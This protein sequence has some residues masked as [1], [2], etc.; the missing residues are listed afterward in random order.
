MNILYFSDL[1]LEFGKLKYKKENFEKIDL[2]IAAGDIGVGLGGVHGLTKMI[3][4]TIPVLYVSGNHEYYN[5]EITLTDERL[6]EFCQKTPNI[7]FLQNSS[8]EFINKDKIYKFIGGT[9]W[10]DFNLNG[11]HNSWFA[12]QKAKNVMND[13][14]CIRY[15]NNLL[16]PGLTKNLHEETLRFILLELQ[17]TEKY[18]KIFII[19]HHTPSIQS[20]YIRNELTPAYGSNLEYLMRDYKIDYW[21]HGHV[22][23]TNDYKIYNTQI[24]S[25]PR[26]Y[27]N[28]ETN[29]EFDPYKVITLN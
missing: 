23:N 2:I 9:L 4:S 28:Y 1:H 18:D 5:K 11:E 17:N 14:R 6:L 21:I 15:K 19:T 25:N 26:G 8:F 3:P 13:Y 12:M 27:V 29:P 7:K 16:T 24:L 10:T 22:H 20:C